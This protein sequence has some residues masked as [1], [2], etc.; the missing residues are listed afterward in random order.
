MYGEE[1]R[2]QL[3]DLAAHFEQAV[4]SHGRYVDHPALT[5]ENGVVS[6]PPPVSDPMPL[7]LVG[8]GA[9]AL[10]AL[11][12]RRHESDRQRLRHPNEDYARAR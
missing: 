9:V 2:R 4:P 1:M 7:V 8:L 5:D 11:L 3:D 6:V 12:M 10:A